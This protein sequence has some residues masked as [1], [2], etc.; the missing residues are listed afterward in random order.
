MNSVYLIG[1]LVRDPEPNGVAIKFTVAHNEKWR[2]KDG[3]EQ[4]RTNFID[5]V[6]FGKTGEI[7]SNCTK[8]RRICVEGKLVYQQWEKDGQKR[9]KIEVSVMRAYPFDPRK[10]SD[11]AEY[12]AP[13]AAQTP[14]PKQETFDADIPF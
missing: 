4:E 3:S 12:A 11:A 7:I 2:S 10:S 6:A 13:D 5:C 1:N 14:A 8:G 9:S